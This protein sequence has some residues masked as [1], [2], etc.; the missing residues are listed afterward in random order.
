M[1]Q[2]LILAKIID[3][4]L[5]AQYIK[6]HVPTIARFGGTIIFRSTENVPVLGSE[7]W[8]VVA[9]QEW[10]SSSAFDLWWVSDE[11]KPWAHIRDRAA[12]L[13]I[14]KCQSNMPV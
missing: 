4:D 3:R 11:Y 2:Y 10:P 14:I 13:V 9:I 8:D 12:D 6:G 7:N 1:V 5:F